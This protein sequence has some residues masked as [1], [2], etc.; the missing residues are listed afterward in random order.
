MGRRLRVHLPFGIYHVMLRGNNGQEIFFCDEDRRHMSF[1]LQDGIEK[2]GHSIFAFC[3]MSNHV[4][5]AVQVKES[6][7][8][9]IMKNLGQRYSY[10]INK[11]YGRIGHLF[12]GRFKSILVGGSKYRTELIRYI[13]LNPVRAYLVDSPEKYFWSSHRTYLGL[14]KRTWIMTHKILKEFGDNQDEMLSN[15]E[16]FVLQGIGVK[17]E[18]DFK[19][20]HSDGI[21]GDPEFIESFLANLEKLKNQGMKL[22]ELAAKLCARLNISEVELRRGGKHTLGAY[23]QAL[24]AFFTLEFKNITFE[25]LAIFL[26]RDASGLSKLAKNLKQESMRSES[27]AAQI[28]ELRAWIYEAKPEMSVLSV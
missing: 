20:G 22:P 17:T 2:Y 26:K 25:E 21:L 5:L 16:G 4:H 9:E 6:E 18:V 15:F 14:E 19:V 7:L 13:H 1:L 24:L 3:F 8:S 23:A 10:Y 28:N 12:Q 11:K 27:V